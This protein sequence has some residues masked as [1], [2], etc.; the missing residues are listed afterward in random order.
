M[1]NGQSGSLAERATKG[2]YHP[3]DLRYRW[4]WG[5]GA[6]VAGLASFSCVDSSTSDLQRLVLDQ[7]RGKVS[8]V[9]RGELLVMV[10]GCDR[11]HTPLVKEHLGTQPGF[12]RRLSGHPEF[13]QEM[14]N[15]KTR[16]GQLVPTPEPNTEFTSPWGHRYAIN[17]TPDPETGIG[18]WTEEMFVLRMTHSQHWIFYSRDSSSFMQAGYQTLTRDDWRAVFAYLKT[19]PPVRNRVPD[20]RMAG[21]WE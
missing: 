19:V 8:L 13:N 12:S 14:E 10:A 15:A 17:L 7:G 16:W 18:S 5:L 20:L 1:R 2:K 21:D 11:C 9:A 3:A 6:L 4:V